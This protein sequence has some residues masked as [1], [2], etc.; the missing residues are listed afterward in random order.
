MSLVST[1]YR[2]ITDASNAPVVGAVIIARLRPVGAAIRVDDATECSGEVRAVTDGAGFYQIPLERNGN[3][4]PA[5]TYWEIEERIPRSKGGT[6]VWAVVSGAVNFNIATAGIQ[7]VPEFFP[8]VALSLEAGDLRYEPLGGGGGGGN[9]SPRTFAAMNLTVATAGVMCHT[10]DQDLDYVNVDGVTNW[11][12]LNGDPGIVWA[13][14]HGAI[15]TIA[16]PSG[17]VMTANT[18]AIKAARD[19]TQ[20]YENV[21]GYN[22]GKGTLFF[23]GTKSGCVYYINGS[24]GNTAEVCMQ[25]SGQNFQANVFAYQQNVCIDGGSIPGNDPVFLFDRS[26]GG[27]D[28]HANFKDID[29]FGNNCAILMDDGGTADNAGIWL[30]NVRL[31]TNTVAHVNNAPLVL[32]D[33]FWIVWEKGGTRTSTTVNK[34]SIIFRSTHGTLPYLVEIRDLKL[35]HGNLRIEHNSTVLGGSGGT[36][37]ISNIVIENMAATMPMIDI[38]ADP[39]ATLR[40]ISNVRIL[41]FQK[42]D[43]AAGA[44]IRSRGHGKIILSHW[45]IDLVQPY[46]DYGFDIQGTRLSNIDILGTELATSTGELFA[47][48]SDLGDIYNVKRSTGIGN[49]HY[50]STGSQNL[51]YANSGTDG[52]VF[53]YATEAYGRTAIGPVGVD[54]GPGSGVKDSRI[55]R[56]A[57]G[58]AGLEP[59]GSWRTGLNITANRPSA[60]TVGVGSQFYDTTLHMPIWSDGA[61]WRDAMHNA[62]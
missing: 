30:E 16:P 25:G 13:T 56:K 5:N 34:G 18:I 40:E 27:I 45:R 32:V 2:T 42:A 11:R 48:G 35:E 24:L 15:P 3:L 7:T 22:R 41:N 55:S 1:G 6:K 43:S 62:V 39:A 31:F 46:S 47:P 54:F 52:E 8:D 60:V 21:S 50:D 9:L 4:T 53:G 44:F 49:Y 20:A 57:V 10:T 36:W 61:V 26:V 12:R 38:I 28:Q 51:K 33:C 59:D 29:I 17:A 58:V 23:P 37:N 14:D 19:E